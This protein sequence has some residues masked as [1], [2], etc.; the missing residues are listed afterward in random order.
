M[1]RFVQTAVFGIVAVFMVYAPVFSGSLPDT[2]Q[3]RCYDN[4][5]QIPCPEPG[6]PFFGQ[7]G[8]YVTNPQSYTKLDAQG[9]DLPVSATYWATVRDNVTGLIWEVK[10]AKD[11]T[12]DYTNPNDADNT[13]T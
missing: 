1:S 3:V 12:K 5:K 10:W 6:Q 7:D 8:N 9:K 2:G 4:T 13:Y 11:G